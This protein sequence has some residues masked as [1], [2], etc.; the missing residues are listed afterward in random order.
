MVCIE[1]KLGNGK[2]RDFQLR[3]KVF[4][5]LLAA[6]AG[7]MYLRMRGYAQRKRRIPAPDVL[8]KVYS[9]CEITWIITV[10]TERKNVFQA[11]VY[12]RVDQAC[13]LTSTLSYTGQMRHHRKITDFILRYCHI[14]RGVAGIAEGAIRYGCKVRVCDFQRFD[15]VI[16]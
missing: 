11:T 15:G 12:V 4:P 2:I 7:R 9:M 6:W 13:N 3:R 8:N 14:P 1:E 5:V 16:Q 10:T